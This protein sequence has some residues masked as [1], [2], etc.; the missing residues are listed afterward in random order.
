MP[1]ILI[2][3]AFNTVS[4]YSENDSITAKNRHYMGKCVKELTKN[5]K[6]LKRIVKKNNDNLEDVKKKIEGLKTEIK[7]FDNQ[8]EKK[9]NKFILLNSK[10]NPYKNYYTFVKSGKIKIKTLDKNA[11]SSKKLLFNFKK[12]FKNDAKAVETL[13]LNGKEIA[14]T[15]K[16]F[17]RIMEKSTPILQDLCESKGSFFRTKKDVKIYGHLASALQSALT[18]NKKLRSE[19]KT[20]QDET[21]EAVKNSEE[22]Q[23]K[24]A[25]GRVNVLIGGS[26][27]STLEVPSFSFQRGNPNSFFNRF[28]SSYFASK[29]ENEVLNDILKDSQNNLTDEEKKLL[30]KYVAN[31][32]RSMEVNSILV[33]AR[34]IRSE[35]AA[36]IKIFKTIEDLKD[37]ESLF[38][39][40]NSSRHAM[41]LE[42][43]KSGE[44]M[45]IKLH[46]PCGGLSLLNK[47]NILSTAIEHMRRER[48]LGTL[49][50]EMPMEEF[51]EK[52]PGFIQSLTA[53]TG[54]RK[55]PQRSQ[56]LDFTRIITSLSD[57][58]TLETK[59]RIQ[60][61]ANCFAQ[62]IRANEKNY[63]GAEL[64]KKV[65][66]ETLKRIYDKMFD[67]AEKKLVQSHLKELN[68]Q[69]NQNTQK[70]KE[71]KA[72][73]KQKEANWDT[74]VELA[75]KDLENIKNK[76]AENDSNPVLTP[77]ELKKSREYL[78][79]LEKLPSSPDDF[80][81]VLRVLRHD[82]YKARRV[83]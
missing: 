52:A 12:F 77:A 1:K 3:D 58:Y 42:L 78:G 65:R 32:E 80:Y 81:H 75:K 49:R 17:R 54:K 18:S 35:Q 10:V 8:T 83:R 79:K 62:R 21:H 29:L 48:I 20:L 67:E 9:L 73:R 40:V 82:I 30:E 38:L 16:N 28:G 4:N 41:R 59:Q 50:M 76:L 36:A 57:K 34:D 39:D 26:I 45:V 23:I 71:E 61:A 69:L 11:S 5:E 31:L 2:K 27:A 6:G 46:D 14:R 64:Y 33:G 66:Q 22:I 13:F 19:L 24:H 53:I 47:F 70:A 43:Q 55:F 72:L 44:N 37:G 51:N 25:K 68:S 60:T 15:K 74:A 63:L 56:Y 7:K